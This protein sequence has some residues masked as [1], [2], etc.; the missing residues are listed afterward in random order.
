MKIKTKVECINCKSM[1]YPVTID[2]S[3]ENIQDEIIDKDRRS[4]VFVSDKQRECANCQ[5]NGIVL[6]C[7]R[8]SQVILK[9]GLVH[10]KMLTC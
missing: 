9:W 5:K 6:N 3:G 4:I 7:I 10:N 1:C 8:T 2:I